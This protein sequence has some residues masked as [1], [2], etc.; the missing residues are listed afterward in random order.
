MTLL[1]YLKQR[2]SLI[3]LA[4]LTLML[5]VTAIWAFASPP[6]SSPDEGYHAASIWCANGSD[7][8][9]CRP[10]SE[11]T[12]LI[13][14]EFATMACHISNSAA[15]AA[16]IHPDGLDE[17]GWV[18][19]P[20]STLNTVA[21]SYPNTF[22]RAMNLF[23]TDDTVASLIAMRI[24]N[25]WLAVLLIFSVVALAPR[26]LRQAVTVSWLVA[27][28]P[29]GL[30]IV[31][32]INPSSWAI[33]GC[34][35]AWAGMYGLLESGTF[36]RRLAYAVIL[37]IALGMAFASRTDGAAIALVGVAMGAALSPTGR[38][39]VQRRRAM[40]LAGAVLAA[41]IAITYLGTTGQWRLLTSTASVFTAG[42]FN[43]ALLFN[44]IIELPQLWAGTLGSWG[45]IWGL[46]W[47]DV[48][49]PAIV[50]VL[51]IAAFGSCLF[52]GLS[53]AFPAKWLALGIVGSLMTVMPIVFLQYQGNSVGQWVQPRYLLPGLLLFLGLALI[54]RLPGSVL[55][56][57]GAQFA[58]L[59]TALSLTQMVSLHRLIRRYESGLAYTSVNLN[60]HVEWWWHSL[61]SPLLT[62]AIGSIAFA[63]VALTALRHTSRVPRALPSSSE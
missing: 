39:V 62:W 43:T 13:P 7:Q 49:M 2:N 9:T 27:S 19:Y 46:G 6:G 38:A 15:S 44:N 57:S 28:I 51:G 31:A 10:S 14:V 54:G 25:A 59:G 53:S 52:W 11:T 35:V 40:S 12:V 61:P 50:G 63:V 56:L 48:P 37:V 45:G 34:G 58:F 22:Y 17:A 32:S 26:T 33:T 55:R 23:I 18:E 21:G 20:R 42:N 4:M 36:R 5:V 8:G 29:L 3:F 60:D 41:L 24:I 30:F 16:C 47:F 1:A